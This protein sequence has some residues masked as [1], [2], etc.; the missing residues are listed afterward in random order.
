MIFEVLQRLFFRALIY[1]AW[2][3][4]VWVAARQEHARMVA[5]LRELNEEDKED[6]Q[7]S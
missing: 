2:N 5:M 4:L 3:F 7:G 6:G 1:V